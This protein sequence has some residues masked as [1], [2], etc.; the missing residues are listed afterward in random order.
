MADPA[1]VSGARLA[2][3]PSAEAAH[4]CRAPE[5]QPSSRAASA[6]SRAGDEDNIAAF[7]HQSLTYALELEMAPPNFT[8]SIMI[9]K[10]T[11]NGQIAAACVP[12]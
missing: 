4:Q 3:S 2:P 11:R 1:R 7:D 6:E 8:N 9:N 10:N 5:A 12:M